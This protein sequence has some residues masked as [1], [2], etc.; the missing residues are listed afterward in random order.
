MTA[1]AREPNQPVEVEAPPLS[2]GQM[3]WLR[4]RRHKMAMAGSIVLI[5]LIACFARVLDVFCR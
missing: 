2:L 1:E 5:L 3:A 4:F